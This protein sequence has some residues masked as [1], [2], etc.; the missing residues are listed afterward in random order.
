M[1]KPSD[2]F[3]HYSDRY[4]SGS[5]DIRTVVRWQSEG[6]SYYEKFVIFLND[7]GKVFLNPDEFYQFEK[8][9]NKLD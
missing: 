1:S 3:F 5:F 9:F 6:Q 8:K 7:G 2:F 4:R